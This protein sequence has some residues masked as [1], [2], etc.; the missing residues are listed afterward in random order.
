MKT[1]TLAIVIVGLA[2]IAGGAWW[3]FMDRDATDQQSA[4]TQDET[5]QTRGTEEGIEDEPDSDPEIT[6][7]ITYT[8]T[9]FKMSLD[10]LKVG[11]TVLV[12]NDS[13]ETLQFSSDPHPQHTENPELNLPVLRP[14][15]QE[16][17]VITEPGTWGFHNH[18]NDN[19]SASIT[20]TD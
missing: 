15:E 19:H 10:N 16:T 8:D 20:V 17:I 14:G 11:S 18:L 3:L 4:A 12:I 9:G 6:S 13:S 7:T 1:T 2:L 5:R